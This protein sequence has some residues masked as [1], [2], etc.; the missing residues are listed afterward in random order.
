MEPKEEIL[1]RINSDPSKLEAL[2]D[3]QHYLLTHWK[4][5]SQHLNYR[6]FFTINS[7]ISLA[8]ENDKVFDAYHTFIL[9]LVKDKKINGLRIDHIDGLKKPGRY[10]EKLR[11]SAG[12]ETYIVAEKILRRDEQVPQDWPLE[13]TT[14]YDFLGIVNNLFTYKKNF[15]QLK[16]FYQEFTGIE[17]SPQEI[18][19]QKKKLILM[20]YKLG[21]LENLCRMFEEEN[22][23]DGKDPLITHESIKS[24]IAEFLV[25]FPRYRSYSW[26]FPLSDEDKNIIKKVLLR[27]EAKSPLLK[28]TLD[29]IQNL[30][31][32]Q[33]GL[34]QKQK[35]AALQFFLRCMQY[36]GPLM[37]KGVEDTVMYYYNCFIAHN[38]VGDEVDAS[39]ISI[40][41][42]HEIMKNRRNTLPLTQ[43]ATSTHDTK[44]GEDIRARLN[45]ISEM[46]LEWIKMVNVWHESN[47]H[48]KTL[49]NDEKGPSLNEEY[50]IYQSLTGVMPFN[51][52]I[53]ESLQKRL[54]EYLVKSLREAKINTN[55]NE[56]NKAYEKAVLN[57]LKCILEPNSEFLKSF[58]PFQKKIARYGIFNSLTQLF[59]KAT[60]PGI[61]DFYQGTELWDLSLVDPDNRRPVDYQL[62]ADILKNLVREHKEDSISFHKNLFHNP[63]NGYLKL[64]FTR[65]LMKERA[66]HPNLFT[67]GLYLP[68][69]VTGNYKE[70]ILAFARVYNDTWYMIIVPLYLSLLHEKPCSDSE[71]LC[72]EWE[73]TTVEIPDLAPEK[74]SFI[75]KVEIINPERKILIS[76]IMEVPFPCFLKGTKEKTVGKA[77]GSSWT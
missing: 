38:E 50:F 29:V 32:D 9:N 31:I 42:F 59:L 26:Y 11:A 37:A 53:N 43:N 10:I 45:V 22:F 47:Q 65:M 17:E 58:L 55:W 77:G 30:L 61:P 7:L 67:Y 66:L 51:Q 54:D 49:V 34:S 6:R 28:K 70:H 63:E 40:Q 5:A 4:E 25:C 24:A 73:D 46:S 62:R 75:P 15:P 69:K 27:A 57:F 1:N 64:W 76:S 52:E 68:L 3:K 2:L 71:S 72:I 19:Y 21:D 23:V 12:D 35:E 8:M 44:R 20:T 56:P 74:W 60:C 13:G 14:G 39:G 48:Y 18:I 36:S 41:E 33:K 16:Q